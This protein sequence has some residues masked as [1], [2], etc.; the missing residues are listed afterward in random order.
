MVADYVATGET[1]MISNSLS[2]KLPASIEQDV[3]ELFNTAY[4]KLGPMHFE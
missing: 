3:R 2:E 1:L 4:Q